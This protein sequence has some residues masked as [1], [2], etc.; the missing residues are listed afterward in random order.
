MGSAGDLKGSA[1]PDYGKGLMNPGEVTTISSSQ[2]RL[3]RHFLLGHL[4][5]LEAAL[6]GTSN[7][8]Q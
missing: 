7:Y 2:P 6:A 1:D 4:P 5:P 8:Y 3:F